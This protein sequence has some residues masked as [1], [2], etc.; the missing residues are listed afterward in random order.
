MNKPSK[1]KAIELLQKSIEQIDIVRDNAIKT[2]EFSMSSGF[3]RWQTTTKSHIKS[4]FREDSSNYKDFINIRFYPSTS[5]I[6]RP[7]TYDEKQESFSKD[8]NSAFGLLS[9]M[10][11][12]VQDQWEDDVVE[13]TDK[14]SESSED[15]PDTGKIFIVYGHDKLALRSAESLIYELGLKPIKVTPGESEGGYVFSTIERLAKECCFSLV[16]L[17]PDDEGKSKSEEDY[18]DRARQNI[19]FEWGYFNGV[20][21]KKHVCAAAKE[22]V[23]KPS[24]MEGIFYYTFKDEVNEIKEEFVKRLKSCGI[25]YK[26]D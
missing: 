12:Q 2:T 16:L 14:N 1:K 11:D 7:N 9:S 3:I 4:I 20:Y 18:K 25:K 10:L 6:N 26:S 21:G 19:I 13:I 17:T 5:Y 22:G 15:I 24:D 23:E 8:F